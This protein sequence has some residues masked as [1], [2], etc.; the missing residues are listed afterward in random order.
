MLD[1]KKLLK[2]IKK[3]NLE[4]YSEEMISQ[5]S[6]VIEKTLND[7]IKEIRNKKRIIANDNAKQHLPATNVFNAS[8]ISHFPSWIKKDIENV[9]VV[10]KSKKVL[11]T[12]DGRKYHAKNKLNDLSGGEWTFFLN[13]V[14]N[15]RYPTTGEDSFAHHIRKEHP[16]PKPPQLMEEIIKFFTKEGELV[17]D[18]FMG[19]GG[20]LLG[21]SMCNRKAVGIDLSNKYIDLYKKA[22]KFLGLKEQ[23]T[24][25]ANSINFLNNK[26]LINKHIKNEEV[27]L[28]LIDPPY[29]DM[30][31]RVRTG[32]SLKKTGKPSSTPFTSS[33]EDLGNMPWDK[34]LSLFVT[35]IEKS[36]LLLK[37]KGHIVVFIKDLQP[38]DG[39]LNLLH[40]DIIKSLDQIDGLNYLGTKIWA[41]QGVNLY[42][43]GYPYS[44]VSNQIHQYIMIFRKD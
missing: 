9:Q 35:S 33:Q 2:I 1:K 11:Q 12:K 41:D 20:S 36:M 4:N 38:K 10:G 21:A 26:T 28:I 14:L 23:T 30:L 25:E 24:I 27:S 16:S 18:Y 40:C 34:F 15:T 17:F 43:Y 3:N 19:V 37:H 32:E 39:E 5:L 13:S 8:E 42:P 44:Y 22:N 6:I 7:K 31:S 29:G